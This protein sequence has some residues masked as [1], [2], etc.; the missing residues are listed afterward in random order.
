MYRASVGGKDA[1]S[2]LYRHAVIR[3]MTE[4]LPTFSTRRGWSMMPLAVAAVLMSWSPAPTLTQRF[5]EALAALDRAL[6]RRRRT[7]R[8]YQGFIKALALHSAMLIDQ[9]VLHLRAKSR[10]CAGQHWQ[11]GEF[12]P[13]G[14]DSSKIDAP[15]TKGNEALGLAGKDKCC[16]QMVLLLLIHLGSRLPWAWKIGNANAAERTLLRDMLDQ[17]P[18]DVLLV[19]DA[20]FTGYDL[21]CELQSRGLHFLIRVGNNVRLLKELGEYRREGKNTVYLWPLTRRSRRPLTLRLIQV[22]KAYLVTN[23]LESTR[24]SKKAAGDLYRR[25]WQIEIAFR[26]LKQTL[27][28]H[29]VR[30]GTAQHCKLELAWAVIG[31]WTLC[32]IGAVALARAHIRPQWLSIGAALTALR[33]GARRPDKL[34]ELRGA[35]RRARLDVYQRRGP[36]ASRNWPRKKDPPQIRTPIIA[37]ASALEVRQAQRVRARGQAA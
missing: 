28:R 23:V 17:L 6:P 29:A 8:T 30:S 3:I 2:P 20:G 5:S 32:L 24:L 1:A 9:T 19:A 14:A 15:R 36:K 4:V 16:P 27:R 25:R 26:S 35:L 10:A 22:G 11:T 7:G 37:T 31:M 33:N 13:I 12:V 18:P 21:L 34:N